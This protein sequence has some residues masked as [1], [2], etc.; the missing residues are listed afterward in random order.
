MTKGEGIQDLFGWGRMAG[1]FSVITG[2]V[3]FQ[4]E[5]EDVVEAKALLDDLHASEQDSAEI[6]SPPEDD[7]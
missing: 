2:P 6:D 4:V 5:T 1:G 7:A 3:A